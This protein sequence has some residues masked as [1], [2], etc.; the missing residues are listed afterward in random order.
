[1]NIQKLAKEIIAEAFNGTIGLMSKDG[2]VKVYFSSGTFE[3]NG[4]DK[5]IFDNRKRKLW[6]RQGELYNWIKTNA[7]SWEKL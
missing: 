7:T 3:Y 6:K 1:M 5:A 2:T 4:L